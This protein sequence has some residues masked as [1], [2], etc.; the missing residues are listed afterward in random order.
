MGSPAS[1]I[2]W[3]SMFGELVKSVSFGSAAYYE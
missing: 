2:L 1:S 3:I